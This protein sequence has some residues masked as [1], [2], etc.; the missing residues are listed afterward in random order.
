MISDLQTEQKESY[1][2]HNLIFIGYAISDIN[3]GG[4]YTMKIIEVLK[5]DYRDSTIVGQYL[6]SCSQVPRKRDG[7]WLV[8]T[9]ISKKN[10][11]IDIGD[12]GISRSFNFPFLLSDNPKVSV[13]PPVKDIDYETSPADWYLEM[14]IKEAEYKQRALVVLREEINQIRRLVK[15]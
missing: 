7:T 9:N 13:P 14:A 1:D 10:K 4:Y 5:G 12:C 15:E 11:T 6:N 2:E 8:Y 3:E